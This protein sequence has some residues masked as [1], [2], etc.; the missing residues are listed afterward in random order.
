MIKIE[1]NFVY[2]INK[3]AL[4]LTAEKLA[5]G[6]W[7]GYCRFPQ[8]NDLNKACALNSSLEDAVK[9]AI[10]V[11]ILRARNDEIWDAKNAADDNRRR[12]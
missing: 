9:A 6:E 8:D 12:N 7:A 11:R 2:T 5:T 3:F 1:E 4:K 10:C